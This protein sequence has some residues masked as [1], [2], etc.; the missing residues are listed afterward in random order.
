MLRKCAFVLLSVFL[1]QYGASPQVVMASIVLFL[2]T[3]AH[4]TFAPFAD[5]YH[6]RVES[7]GLHICQLQ[8]LVTLVSNMIGR[9]DPLVPQSPIGPVSSI[10]VVA[11]VFLSTG[12]FFY[13]SILWTVRRSQSSDGAIGIVARCCGRYITCCSV[14]AKSKAIGKDAKILQSS[15]MQDKRERSMARSLAG[16]GRI[17][18]LKGSLRYNVKVAIRMKR[19]HEMI[20]SHKVT[21]VA[22]MKMVESQQHQSRAR[23]R[24]RLMSRLSVHSYPD[25][26]AHEKTTVKSDVIQSDS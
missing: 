10:I 11:F 7:L 18:T 6:N 19:G 3:S 23:L 1:K 16:A 5:P 25:A 13:V 22:R 15:R 14:N 24:R 21:R 2:A 8:L 4:L 9:V 20:R 12:I 17:G 26:L